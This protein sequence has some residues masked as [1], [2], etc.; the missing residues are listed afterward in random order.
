MQPV[1]LNGRFLSQSMT[2][3]QRFS[4]EIASA[5]DQHVASGMWP[6]TTVLSPSRGRNSGV[7]ESAERYRRLHHKRVGW[8]RGHAWEQAELPLAA[9]RGIL[10]NLGNTAPLL[11]GLRQV[12]VIHDASV[13]DTPES[14]SFRFRTWYKALQ[15]G[16]VRHGARIVTVSR[17]SRSQ[18]AW[19][20][21]IDPACIAVMYEGA[22]HVL[23]VVADP[24][25]LGR[26][27]LRK[28]R[29]ALVVGSRVAHKNVAALGE[30]AAWLKRRGIVIAS[31][32]GF[33]RNVFQ[34]TTSR[35]GGERQLG[36]VSDG[37]LRALYENAACL[38]FPSRYEGFG[39]PPLEAMACACP[40]L[41]ASGGAVREICGER[42]LYFT[43]SGETSVIKALE[44]LF[45]ENGLADELRAQGPA[46]AANFTWAAS[47]RILGDVVRHIS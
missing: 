34:N 45:D 8:M 14:Y 3:V 19:R 35:D 25:V 44:R 15:R 28:R 33:D 20:L 10:V 17:F 26:N 27:G 36:R 24:A 13:F 42:A 31:A 23:R 7:N 38:L 37:E 32:G 12:V 43:N 2:G 18:I 22:E 5:I 4:T 30:A 9:R 40:V 16:L 21:N 47:A 41:A 1:F 6:E 29:Y 46:H 11:G 39:L